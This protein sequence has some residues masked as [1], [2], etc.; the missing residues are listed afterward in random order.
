MIGLLDIL[1]FSSYCIF[2]NIYSY[3]YNKHIFKNLLRKG[4]WTSEHEQQ[5]KFI[6]PVLLFNAFSVH[7]RLRS[8]VVNP[9]EAQRAMCAGWAHAVE[10]V[11]LVHTGSTTHTWV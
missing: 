11:D 3:L 10:P 9:R 4:R 7:T 2:K 5:Y 8:T 1:N 6:I